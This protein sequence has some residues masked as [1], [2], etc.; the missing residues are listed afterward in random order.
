MI[1]Y[2]PGPPLH[3]LSDRR[4]YQEHPDYPHYPPPWFHHPGICVNI[5]FT[6]RLICYIPGAE[7]PQRLGRPA[8]MWGSVG[9]P[10]ASE[11]EVNTLNQMYHADTQ[12]LTICGTSRKSPR[13]RN[14][15]GRGGMNAKGEASAP[16]A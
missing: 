16:W 2:L 12:E 1:N 10:L 5:T 7:Y 6:N 14:W 8:G 9:K 11:P 3:H 4:H 13:S 15:V